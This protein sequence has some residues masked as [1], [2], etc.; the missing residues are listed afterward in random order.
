M[1][2]RLRDR[3][4]VITRAA[5]GIGAAC[6]RRFAAEGASLVVDD[7][8][9]DAGAGVADAFAIANVIL[10]LASDEVSFVTG[11]NRLVDGGYTAV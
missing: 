7:V 11:T 9:E 2:N 10:F 4:A 1:P 6:A 5:P 3:V 8:S